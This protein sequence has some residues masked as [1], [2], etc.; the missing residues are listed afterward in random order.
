[1]KCAF[2]EPIRMHR[3]HGFAGA[4]FSVGKV[5]DK[6]RSVI[7]RFRVL[8]IFSLV[9]QGAYLLSYVIVMEDVM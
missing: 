1:M 7:F 2:P 5:I 3:Q 8:S 9:Q 6:G 4:H